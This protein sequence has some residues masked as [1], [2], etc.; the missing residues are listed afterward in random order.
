MEVK[1]AF[2]QQKGWVDVD[3]DRCNARYGCLVD[4]T[5]YVDT[6]FSGLL[7]IVPSDETM[8]KATQDD[9]RSSMRRSAEGIPCPK[10]GAY[11]AEWVEAAQAKAGRWAFWLSLVASFAAYVAIALLVA[12]KAPSWILL[13]IVALSWITARAIM[14]QG[15]GAIAD[16]YTEPAAS[17]RFPR[18][19]GRDWR[20]KT[21]RGRARGSHEG[22]MAGEAGLPS[23]THESQRQ[24]LRPPRSA[25]SNVISA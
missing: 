12:R 25:E 6:G 19:T 2:A 11:G 16:S 20:H 15:T 21:S 5:G 17:L 9:L 3:C 10:C 18:G 22:R 1:R 14:P 4:G 24:S 23:C 7:G 13:V 8:K